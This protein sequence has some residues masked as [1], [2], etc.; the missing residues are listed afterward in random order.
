MQR[1]RFE[2]DSYLREEESFHFARKA[3]V[4]DVPK[5]VH[6]HDYYELFLVEQGAARHF[7]NGEVSELQR[8]DLVFMRPDDA[9]ALQ[10]GPQG[11]TILN[12]MFRVETAD[13]LLAR[14]G[15]DVAGRF[16]WKTGSRPARIA[17][18]GA[19]LERAVN[20]SQSLQTS[21]RSLARIEQYLL[22]MVL[23]VVPHVAHLSDA[24]PAWLVQACHAAQTPDVFSKGAAGFIAAAGRGHEHVCRQTARHLGLS[25]TA[26]VNQVRMQ[27]AAQ[28]LG[29]G[30][31]TIEDIARECG[32]T[33]VSHFYKLFRTH[34]GTTPRDYRLRHHRD[35]MQAQP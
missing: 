10:A 8:G 26:F 34:Y 35:P 25:P 15:D 24:A 3:L 2:I 14:Y 17:L 31:T 4:S 5:I 32:I 27:H 33:N 19:T 20:V 9:H 13:H 23:H 28:R 12:V 21:L 18:G 16:F 7:I 29:E 1:R 11:C 6:D 30:S 22:S